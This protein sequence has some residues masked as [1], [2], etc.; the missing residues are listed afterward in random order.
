MVDALAKVM[1]VNGTVAGSERSLSKHD[2]L[3]A[4]IK[5]CLASSRMSQK[6]L[7][8]IYSPAAYGV[9]R[10]YFPNNESVAK[11]VLNDAFFKVFRDLHQYS[12]QG[13]FEGWIRRIVIHAVSDYIR[14]NSK[15]DS[16]AREVMPEDAFVN[17]EAVDNLSHKE[18][19]LI[20]ETLPDTQRNIFNL[21]VFENMSHKKIAEIMNMK[22]N[23]C[24]WHLNDARRR[25]KEKIVA[26]VNK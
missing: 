5:D 16:Q 8:E 14:R 26:L 10:K 2:E 25:L 24:R 3:R 12:F 13:A 17:T 7:Y 21:F 23:N 22:T 15:P 6:K 4:L 11:E 19:L 20:I 9:I 18:L 1:H